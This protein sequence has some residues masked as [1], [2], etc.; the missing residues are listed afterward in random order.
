MSTVPKFDVAGGVSSY[1]IELI[2]QH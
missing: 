2:S 1:Y